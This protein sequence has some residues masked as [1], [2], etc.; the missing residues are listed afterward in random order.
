MCY[1]CWGEAELHSFI[2]P[3]S[4]AVVDYTMPLCHYAIVTYTMAVKAKQTGDDY[5]QSNSVPIV[6]TGHSLGGMPVWGM[7]E[8]GIL[9]GME[10]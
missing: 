8:Q 10:V 1:G 7:A 3:Q 5:E 4:Y 6:V 2:Y 9:W